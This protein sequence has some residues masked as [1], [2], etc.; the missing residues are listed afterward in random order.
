MLNCD[1]CN[2]QVLEGDKV[3]AVG[4]YECNECYAYRSP[5]AGHE[6]VTKEMVREQ[7]ESEIDAQNAIVTAISFFE[8][9]EN[10][11]DLVQ[12]LGYALALFVTHVYGDI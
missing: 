5:G 6:S 8:H 10:C 9:D 4:A 12:R 11:E 3:I 1:K 2:C 7:Y